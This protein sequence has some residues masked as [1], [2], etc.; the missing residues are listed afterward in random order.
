MCFADVNQHGGPNE[1]LDQLPENNLMPP[2]PNFPL[3][4]SNV[5]G[6]EFLDNVL[7][8]HYN[9][10]AASPPGPAWKCCNCCG[11]PAYA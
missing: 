5:H 7:C 4:G 1:A 8:L 9:L 3:E 2:Y 10:A 6:G 11:M